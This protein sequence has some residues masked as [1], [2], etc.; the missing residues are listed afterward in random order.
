[1]SDET[2]AATPVVHE[3]AHT[4]EGEQGGNASSGSGG[5]TAS[6]DTS[7][8]KGRGRRSPPKQPSPRGKRAAAK[9]AAA[10]AAGTGLA[11]STSTDSNTS[12]ATTTTVATAP[13]V[14]KKGRRKATDMNAA[15]KRKASTGK[16]ASKVVKIDGP[17]AKRH[18]KQVTSE[19]DQNLGRI[20]DP[21]MR[22]MAR[23]GGC[24][25]INS[26]VYVTGRNIMKERLM[27]V[28]RF[29]SIIAN[30]ARRKTVTR[31]DIVLALRRLNEKV[32]GYGPIPV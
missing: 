7:Q 23:R 16:R 15:A 5:D 28:L 18:Q 6:G 26:D 3:P 25:R 21:A 8:G 11:E 2:V 10:A 12:A 20:T 22:R 31:Q 1:M 32:C 13:A 30:H 14:P 9:A 27:L 29:A 4:A 24:K 19:L 17:V